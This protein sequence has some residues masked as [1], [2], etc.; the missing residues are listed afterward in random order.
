[1]NE[2]DFDVIELED[3]LKLPVIDALSYE[4]RVFILVGLLNK[5]GDDVSDDLYVYEKIDDHIA[6]IEDNDLLE[7]LICTFEKRVGIK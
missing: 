3:G 5:A 2:L 1:M 7:K 6:T 4:N